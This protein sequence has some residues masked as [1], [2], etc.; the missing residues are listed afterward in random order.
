MLPQA[1]SRF[2]EVRGVFALQ[3]DGCAQWQNIA[4]SDIAPALGDVGFEEE[5]Q[6]CVAATARDRV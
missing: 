2:R 1:G 6:T 4:I 3:H 5:E